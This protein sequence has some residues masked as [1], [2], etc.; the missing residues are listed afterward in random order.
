MPKQIFDTLV[1]GGGVVGCAIIRELSKYDLSVAL[2]EKESDVGEGTSKGNSAIMHTGFDAK[3][4][5]LEARLVGSGSVEFR[6]QVAPA[7]NLPCEKIGA[8]VIA[9]GAAIRE[10]GG[11]LLSPS[12]RREELRFTG[13]WERVE[14]P[15]AV[16]FLLLTTLL[17]VIFILQRRELQYQDINGTRFWLRNRM[18]PAKFCSTGSR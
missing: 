15:L 3:P 2:V 7:M 9:Y 6:T 5:S 12:L 14:F 1:I 16:A 10:L 4:G 18:Y 17:G 13:T 11:G 8:L